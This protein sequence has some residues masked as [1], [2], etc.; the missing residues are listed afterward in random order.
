MRRV[1]VALDVGLRF[2]S[3]VDRG[4][5]WLHIDGEVVRVEGRNALG[6]SLPLEHETNPWPGQHG[7]VGMQLG[8]L[9]STQ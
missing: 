8:T 6:E 7:R 9:G 1:S 5:V 4:C 2:V 3:V